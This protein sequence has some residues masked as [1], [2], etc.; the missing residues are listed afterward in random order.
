MSNDN[1][2]FQKWI[3]GDS[4][5]RDFVMAATAAIV[6]SAVAIIVLM[7]AFWVAWSL[8]VCDDTCEYERFNK[9]VDDCIERQIYTAQECKDIVLTIGDE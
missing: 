1:T 3:K 4:D 5:S 2:A 7:F 6:G 9:S 8:F